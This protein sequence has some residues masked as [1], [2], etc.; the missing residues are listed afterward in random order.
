MKYLKQFNIQFVGLKEGS[1][2][3]NYTIDNKFFEA[4]NFDEYKS[5][6]IEV[7]L[8]FVKKS[9]LFELSFIAAGTIEIPCD[10]TNELYNQE[11]ASE[12]PLVVKFGPLYNDESEEILILPHEAY[13][14]NVAQFIYEMIVLAVPNKRVHPKVL[15]GTM[16]SEA[17]N[18][19]KELTIKEEKTVVNTDPRWDK[20]KNLI[21][22]K[23][24]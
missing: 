7:S 19:L 2:L 5:S 12:L 15:D 6:S 8:T 3:F 23:K 9:T 17:L 11:I 21:T 14:F 22:E 13:E 20:L 18:K 10:L 24:T 4:F 16:E 1:H